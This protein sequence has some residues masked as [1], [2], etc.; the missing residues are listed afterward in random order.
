MKKIK[1][2]ILLG[3]IA[4]AMFA[5]TGCGKTT[6]NLNKYITIEC[7]GYDSLGT[8]SFSF[9]Y[10]AF[11]K[12]YSGKIK[13]SS[14]DSNEMKLLGLLSGGSSAELLLDVCV[15]Q[16][17]DQARNLSNGDT[18]TL[19]WNCEDE[20]ASEYFNCKLDYS[21]IEYKVTGLTEVGKFN[22]FDYVEVSFSETEPYI[23]AT[24]TQN[25]DQPEMQY[26]RFTADKE[27]NLCNGDIV[28]VTASISGSVDTFVENYGVVIS[29]TERTY[30]VEGLPHYATGVAE[31]PSDVMDAMSAKG[32]EVFRAYVANSWNKP[33]NLISV[34][35]IG[36]YFLTAKPLEYVTRSKSFW[37]ENYVYLVY[38]I[39]ATNPDPE[40]VVEYYYYV[41]YGDIEIQPDGSCSVDVN[42]C[43]APD[44][45]WFSTETFK[46]GSYTYVGYES[47][48][49]LKENRVTSHVDEY[50]YT[51]SVQE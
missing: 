33:E 48:E 50:E 15:S 16:N 24:I 41:Y 26:I 19:T 21:D 40:E 11:E 51:I 27:H 28:T 20:M 7:A 42:T 45:G 43:T 31:I 8:A 34:T 13:L 4:L 38:K 29:E 49:A 1:G 37:T 44:T 39:T 32:E 14:K 9:D 2:F 12:D 35:Y 30:T 47:L 23:I 36:N 3:M 6:V 5:L 18:I 17:L 46:V 10:E 22:P 25:Y